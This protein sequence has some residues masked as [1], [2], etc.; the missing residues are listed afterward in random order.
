MLRGFL[1]AGA[2]LAGLSR[3][4]P[5]R[6]D[7][8]PLMGVSQSVVASSG[9][10]Q[11]TTFLAAATGMSAAD[12]AAY[13][14][15][16]CGIASSGASLDAVWMFAAPTAA[17]SQLN[18]L[19]P[20]AYSLT[21]NNDVLLDSNVGVIGDANIAYINTNYNPGAGGT[22]LTQNSASFGLCVLNTR[23]NNAS[24][25]SGYFG[26]QEGAGTKNYN[27]LQ[28]GSGS[29]GY[30]GIAASNYTTLAPYSQNQGQ[31]VANRTSS[32]SQTLYYNGTSFS[33][34][35]TASSTIYNANWYILANDVVGTGAT[36]YSGDTLAYVWVGAGLT[37]G[38]MSTLRSLFNT[39]LVTR[40]LQPVC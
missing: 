35:S 7:D 32:S 3:A 25:N 9:C 27:Y 6:A 4:A 39:F 34:N 33:S 40:H 5:A 1:I 37:T 17:I 19:N 22:S 23:A 28:V 16:I 2:V 38:Q 15:L 20:S 21:W 11:A 26:L 14:A 10:S 31:W 36:N 30:W 29:N 12:Q 24:I 13:T 18:L 8:M